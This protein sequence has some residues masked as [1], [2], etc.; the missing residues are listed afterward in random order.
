MNSMGHYYGYPE[1]CIKAFQSFIQFKK[2]SSERQQ[3]AKHGFV[4]CQACAERILKGEIQL[5]ELILSTRQAP[6]PFNR[7]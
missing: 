5:H 2:I 6:K 7:V 4:P 3:A 1:C